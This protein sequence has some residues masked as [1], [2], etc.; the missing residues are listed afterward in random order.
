MFPQALR[1]H[2]I[3]G[4]PPVLPGP[5]CRITCP[6]TCGSHPHLGW[7]SSCQ[8]PIPITFLQKTRPF[9]T[10]QRACCTSLFTPSKRTF[11]VPFPA[12]APCLLISENARD[13]NR[14]YCCCQQDQELLPWNRNSNTK[15]CSP[16]AAF[17]PTCPLDSSL[18]ERAGK[19]KEADTCLCHFCA[20][21]SK[22]TS[23]RWPC[24]F[25]LGFGMLED[26][27]H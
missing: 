11:A 26:F 17:S 14:T 22:E 12:P 2:S 5:G 25:L 20:V 24:L 4:S 13:W 6:S 10:P 23:F 3:L 7:S 8:A 19:S 15:H 18:K 1:A 16:D 27:Q 21:P 9:S